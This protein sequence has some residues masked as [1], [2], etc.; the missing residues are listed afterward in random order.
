MSND[1][2]CGVN[3]DAASLQWFALAVKPRFDKAVANALEAKGFPTFLPLYT[4]QHKYATRSREFDLPL[5]PGYI[6]CRFGASSR[7]PILTT[8]GVTQILGFGN[9]PMPVDDTEIISLQTALKAR[10]RIEPFPFLQVGQKVRIHEGAL[11][12]IEG[13]VVSFRQRLR[14]VV[15]ITLLERS[16]LLEIERD[17]VEAFQCSDRSLAE[18]TPATSQSILD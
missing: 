18:V 7:L 1:N 11:A 6:F 17:Q 10:L 8:P 2:K 4:K 16:V 3:S 12:G 15:S 13:I 5:F 14:I 9:Q